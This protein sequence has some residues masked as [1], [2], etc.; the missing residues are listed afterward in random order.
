MLLQKN[1]I[2]TWISRT[3]FFTYLPFPLFLS[4]FDGDI[5]IRHSSLL[6][7]HL[8]FSQHRT[9]NQKA[10]QQ[11]LHLQKLHLPKLHLHL[12]LQQHQHPQK[13]LQHQHPTERKNSPKT[14]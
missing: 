12:L 8:M 4:L 7:S 1:H 2:T 5:A 3:H 10:N 14:N 13:L 6:K 11:K 9:T